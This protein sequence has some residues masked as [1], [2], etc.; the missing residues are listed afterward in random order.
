[1]LKCNCVSASSIVCLFTC[2]V[3][4]LCRKE[5]ILIWNLNYDQHGKRFPI[6]FE[7]VPPVLMIL[8][9]ATSFSLFS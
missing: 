5:K 2:L 9:S 6:K 3:H 4:L 7:V 8:T 1:M